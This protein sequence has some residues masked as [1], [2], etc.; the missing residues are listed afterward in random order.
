MGS[1]LLR[2]HDN[3]LYSYDAT[4]IWDNEPRNKAVRDALEEAIHRGLSVVV[5]P[6]LDIKDL[7]DM[8]QAGLNVL[9]L[10]QNNTFRGL[11]A[12]LEF[13]RWKR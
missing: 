1:D 7:N 8:S 4:Y 9:A 6:K 2:V 10:V 11:Q 5:W 13:T 12:E 3:I